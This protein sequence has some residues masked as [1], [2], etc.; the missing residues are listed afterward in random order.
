MAIPIPQELTE[1]IQFM[2][3]GPLRSVTGKSAALTEFASAWA[4]IKEGGGTTEAETMQQEASIQAFE[5]WTQYIP[6][7]TAFMQIQWGDRTLTMAEPPQK[8]TDR[9]NRSWLLIQAEETV[10]RTVYEP[11]VRT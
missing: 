8:V 3:V 11:T 10:E 4:R 7:I 5:I 9:N 2:N 6:G 1:R